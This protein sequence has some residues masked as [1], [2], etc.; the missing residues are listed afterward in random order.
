MKRLHANEG[1]MVHCHFPDGSADKYT[2]STFSSREA[3][4]FLLRVTKHVSD[5]IC[6]CLVSIKFKWMWNQRYSSIRRLN[7]RNITHIKQ[8]KAHMRSL[9]K[10]SDTL[11]QELLRWKLIYFRCFLCRNKSRDQHRWPFWEPSPAMQWLEQL[12]SAF[13]HNENTEPD[14]LDN[15]VFAWSSVKQNECRGD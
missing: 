10:Q 4:R 5:N 1:I 8:H 13:E 14:V 11:D 2:A 12:R 15:V 3:E 7:R 9:K 6:I